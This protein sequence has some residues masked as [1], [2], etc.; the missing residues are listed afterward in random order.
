MYSIL[1]GDRLTITVV[2][3]AVTACNTA[4]HAP[5]DPLSP[6]T[7]CRSL[8]CACCHFCIYLSLLPPLAYHLPLLTLP[9]GPRRTWSPGRFDIG[10]SSLT[11]HLVTVLVPPLLA[12]LACNPP[13][14]CC[15]WSHHVPPWMVT[16]SWSHDGH[17]SQQCCMFLLPASY[18]INLPMYYSVPSVILT[19]CDTP[20]YRFCPPTSDS[21]EEA[22]NTCFAD[23][24]SV[25][26]SPAV[27]FIK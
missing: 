25:L 4:C 18:I 27:D 6:P 14:P 11:W 9:K 22:S 2:P 13:Q 17:L 8:S 23:V 10:V 24:A 1:Q 7:P 20:W 3:A 12:S 26:V 5:A 15:H 21:T 16:L 19:K